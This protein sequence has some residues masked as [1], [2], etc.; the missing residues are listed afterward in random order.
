ME[1][2]KYSDSA[3][4]FAFGFI[5]LCLFF[6][7]CLIKPNWFEKKHTDTTNITIESKK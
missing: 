1:N 2:K 3:K 7:L 5:M 4:S 6:L